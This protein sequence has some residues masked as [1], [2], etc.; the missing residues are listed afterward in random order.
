MQLIPLYQDRPFDLSTLKVRPLAKDKERILEVVE[1]ATGVSSVTDKDTFTA[2]KRMVAELKGI[3][4]ELD[5]AKKLTK[6]PAQQFLN[7]VEGLAKELGEALIV[8]RTRIERML[9]AFVERLEAEEAARAA[10]RK[11]KADEE[12]KRLEEQMKAARAANDAQAMEE[13][14]IAAEMAADIAQMGLRNKEVKVAGGRIEHRRSFRLVDV[15]Q[16]VGAGLWQCVRFE[17]DHLGCNDVVRAQLEK[18]IEP[19]IPG[20]EITLDT[21]VH[22]K[23]SSRIE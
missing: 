22:M 11:K 2:A 21:K 13:A 1:R 3:Q 17:L 14:Q 15:K 8:Q 16:V 23:A 6:T 18:G 7:A 4:Q 9:N 5:L 20:V 19:F 10:E 12:A